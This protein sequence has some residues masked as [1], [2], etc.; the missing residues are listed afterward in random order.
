VEIHDYGAGLTDAEK[1]AKRT[2]IANSL[3]LL[4]RGWWLG[5]IVPHDDF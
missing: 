3:E 4:M 2:P 1:L 5:M